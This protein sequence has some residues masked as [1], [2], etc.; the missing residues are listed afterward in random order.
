[1]AH[2]NSLAFPNM[3]SAS[4]N[5]VNVIEDEI[6]IANRCKLLLLSD[7]TS[8]YNSPT[9]GCGLKQFLFQYNTENTRAVM[10][11]K[12]CKQLSE[13]E[14]CVEADKTTFNDGLLFTGESSLTN[15]YAQNQVLEMTIGLKTVYGDNLNLEISNTQ[16]N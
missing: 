11:D 9:F 5:I 8:L 7:P 2:T 3:F 10:K 6:S 13:F 1:M 15:S 16:E 4:Q 12:I 14:P